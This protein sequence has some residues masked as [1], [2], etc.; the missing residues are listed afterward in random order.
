MVVAGFAAWLTDLSLLV[1]DAVIGCSSP[2]DPGGIVGV[3]LVSAVCAAATALSWLGVL[4]L[5]RVAVGRRGLRT[6]TWMF[7][8]LA[9]AVLSTALVAV[10]AE[11]APQ[12]FNTA[13]CSGS[14][15]PS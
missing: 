11:A 6:P 5:V 7:V 13:D 4:S 10:A 9:L 1:L 15:E 3:L 12:T 2:N 14:L 8:P